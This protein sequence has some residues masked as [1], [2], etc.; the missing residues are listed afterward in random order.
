MVTFPSVLRP[1][2]TSFIFF[3]KKLF[4]GNFYLIV[5]LSI[6]LVDFY[7]LWKQNVFV[8]NE[9]THKTRNSRNLMGSLPHNPPPRDTWTEVPPVGLR[10][11]TTE[12]LK[13]H[14]SV[15]M[16]LVYDRGVRTKN[17]HETRKITFVGFYRGWR[18]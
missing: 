3:K 17:W 7:M 11:R 16:V 15:R 8:D 13:G 9:S 18:V 4:R 5:L 6:C 12:S 14:Q 1:S 2:K 10:N